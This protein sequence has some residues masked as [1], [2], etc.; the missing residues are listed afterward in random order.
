MSDLASGSTDMQPP[1]GAQI[2]TESLGKHTTK[3][4][5]LVVAVG[6]TS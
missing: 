4:P 6:D 5:A 3:P 2:E 1:V